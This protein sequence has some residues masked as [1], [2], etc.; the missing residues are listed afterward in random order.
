TYYLIIVPNETSSSIL[1]S[2][3]SLGISENK[4][5]FAFTDPNVVASILN[6]ETL[7]V[8]LYTSKGGWF[9]YLVNDYV[10]TLGAAKNVESSNSSPNT[11]CLFT[12]GCGFCE[13][14]LAYCDVTVG[15]ATCVRIN[16]QCGY[17]TSPP[18]PQDPPLSTEDCGTM[19]TLDSV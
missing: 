12:S 15:L 10:C 18:N 5:A 2:T 13:D 17:N 11:G 9:D 14:S 16:G 1:E 8:S 3:Q 19:T 6:D 7:S 4:I